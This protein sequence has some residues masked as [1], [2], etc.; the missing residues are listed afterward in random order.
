MT[1]PS[2]VTSASKSTKCPTK[3]SKV[4]STSTSTLDRALSTMRVW[5][6][7]KSERGHSKAA[8]MAV[9]PGFIRWGNPIHNR[10]GTVTATF[11]AA[12]D[13]GRRDPSN[14]RSHARNSEIHVHLR[15]GRL[16]RRPCRPGTIRRDDGGCGG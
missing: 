13:D 8:R 15:P 3:E 10:L 9:G 12:L 4:A 11:L 16:S 5:P 2:T 7:A 6:A 14:R 1:L